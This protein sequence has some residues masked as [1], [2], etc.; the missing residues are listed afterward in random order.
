MVRGEGG[1]GRKAGGVFFFWL[2]P[3]NRR[4][5]W[6]P[7]ATPRPLF[8]PFKHL[9]HT[10]ALKAVIEE[11]KPGAKLVDVCAKGDAVIEE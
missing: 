2:D 1:D 11:C 9:L 5:R 6:Q 3:L 4:R 10:A 7:P 8:P